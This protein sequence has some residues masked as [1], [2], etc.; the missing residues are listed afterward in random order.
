MA[1]GVQG[2]R[3]RALQDALNLVTGSKLAGGT[4]DS[5]TKTRVTEYQRMLRLTAD[6]V[7]GPRTVASLV[8][9]LAEI[10]SGRA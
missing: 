4:Y 6:G 2:D 9:A 8:S 1:T 3:V 10:A 5:A 7:A